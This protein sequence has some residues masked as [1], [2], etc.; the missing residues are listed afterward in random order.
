MKYILFF[1][2]LCAIAPLTAQTIIS[3]SVYFDSGKREPNEK[4]K[5]LLENWLDSLKKNSDKME[6]LQFYVSGF[7]DS[8]G[9]IASNMELSKIRMQSVVDKISLMQFDAAMESSALGESKPKYSNTKPSDRA[10][11]RRVDVLFSYK[12]KSPEKLN[13]DLSTTQS[14]SDK[15]EKKK[16]DCNRDTTITFPQGLMITLNKCDFE[17]YFVDCPLKVTEYLTDKSIMDAGLKTISD[18]GEQL[19][20]GGMFKIEWCSDKDFP[21]PIFVTLPVPSCIEENRDLFLWSMDSRT[22]A[23]KN[24]E[25]KFQRLKDGLQ[26]TALV[27]SPG[28]KNCDAVVGKLPPAI[29]FVAKDKLKLLNVRVYYKCP[30]PSVYE[31][32]ITDKKA[33]RKIRMGLPC[34]SSEPMIYARAIDKQGNIYYMHFTELNNLKFKKRNPICGST[35]RRSLK[36]EEF[37]NSRNFLLTRKYKLHK[38]DFDLT[39]PLE[40]AKNSEQANH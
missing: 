1:A 31:N 39:I 13:T 9:S 6:S 19:T 40:D 29:K 12:M 37:V 8:V 22:K 17:K 3:H 35:K 21:V 25:T 33:E 30:N 15:N 27:L 11:N 10:G 38:S 2:F 23:W 24:T 14:N 34:P 4:Q 32:E 36:P 5:A 28:T 18:K 7:C 16:R 20:T 26:M